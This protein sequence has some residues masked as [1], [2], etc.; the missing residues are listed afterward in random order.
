MA[1]QLEALVQRQSELR[2]ARDDAR[3]AVTVAR[4]A[5]IAGTGEVPALTSAQATYSAIADAV[6]EVEARVLELE[7]QA[8]AQRA[9]AQRRAQVQACEELAEEGAATLDAA[10]KRLYAA[11]GR[12]LPEIAVLIAESTEQQSRFYHFDKAT[13]AAAA[14]AATRKMRAAIEFERTSQ[15][16]FLSDDPQRAQYEGYLR[17]LVG[18]A[19][20]EMKHR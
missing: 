7:R 6:A 20:F 16:G 3:Q 10:T 5:M 2:Q 12:E 8:E 18:A 4:D 1:E 17:S 11:L 13:D 9:E 15:L 19:M 14:S